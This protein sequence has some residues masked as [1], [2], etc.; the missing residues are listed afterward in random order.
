VAD[1]DSASLGWPAA[2][3]PA[4][5]AAYR[6]FAGDRLVGTVGGGET[7]Y[8]VTG[9][10]PALR[11]Q[12]R[13]QALDATG[14]PAARDLSATVTTGGSPDTTAPVPPATAGSVSVRAGSVGTTWL[15]L[16]WLAATDDHGVDAYRIAISDGRTITVPGTAQTVV[17]TGLR[18]GLAYS[19]TV[20]ALDATGNAAAYP[21][22]ASA[23]TNPPYDTGAP[24]WPAGSRLH[25]VRITGTS[26]TLAWP[27]ATDDQGVIGYRVFVDGAPVPTGAVFTPID[28][29]ATTA[30]TT[31]TV[32]GL[33]PGT[34]YTIAVEAGDA[35]G[36]W[37]GSGP[38]L[39]VRTHR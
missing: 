15:R 26:I 7:A 6:I 20:T 13:V 31:F 39:T 17:V 19:F 23:T 12:F 4:G 33:R 2:S 10:A 22:T 25:A 1:A 38:R 16:D 32:T 35:A 21:V 36:K 30:G 34:T 11:Y 9:L 18:P 37:T 14:N 3:D 5:V 8:R 24:R 29:A 27:A 28:T